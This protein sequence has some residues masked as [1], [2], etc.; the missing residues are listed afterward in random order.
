MFGRKSGFDKKVFPEILRHPGNC[1]LITHSNNIKKSKSNNDCVITLENLFERILLWG[2]YEEQELC[3]SLIEKYKN[4]ERYKK[5]N[6][7]ETYYQ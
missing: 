2:D 1:Q 7:I 3:L 4:G 5:E 6:Y